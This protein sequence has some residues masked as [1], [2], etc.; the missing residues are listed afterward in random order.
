MVVLIA[1]STH[2][3]LTEL[4]VAEGVDI[5][6]DSLRKI[7]SGS[8]KVSFNSAPQVLCALS[9]LGRSLMPLPRSTVISAGSARPHRE[10]A[11][12][13]TTLEVFSGTQDFPRLV[14]RAHIARA[15]G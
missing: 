9:V 11:R 12:V 6:Q 10:K 8:P 1:H 2:P 15:R 14:G 4:Q 3:G 7:E 13:I 5:T